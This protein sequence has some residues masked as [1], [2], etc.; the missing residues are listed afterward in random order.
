MNSMGNF[1]EVQ[2]ATFFHKIYN[3]RKSPAEFTDTSKLCVPESLDDAFLRCKENIPKYAIYYLGASVI[4]MA[5]VALG[6]IVL[7]I[8][9]IL[10]ALLFYASSK[11]YSIGNFQLTP[12]YAFYADIVLNILLVLAFRSITQAFLTIIAFLSITGVLIV[13]HASFRKR[14][15]VEKETANV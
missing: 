1:D 14:D 5:L 13:A 2:Q 9:I 3:E 11:E 8:P 15:E 7:L 12:T 4:V 6:H 10:A